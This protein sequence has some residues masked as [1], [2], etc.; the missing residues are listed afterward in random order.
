MSSSQLLSCV[1]SSIPQ[2]VFLFFFHPEIRS[3]FYHT[4]TSTQRFSV[5]CVT[6]CCHDTSRIQE[7]WRSMRY[8]RTGFVITPSIPPLSEESGDC[9]WA[10]SE[11]TEDGGGRNVRTTRAL[12]FA[13]TPFWQSRDKREMRMSIWN[14]R[15]VDSERDPHAVSQSEHKSRSLRHCK[16]PRECGEQLKWQMGHNL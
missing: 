12:Q 13:C 3:L 6:T 10:S 1:Y 5:W 15:C 9:A 16:C 8:G 7:I 14:L 2:C 4:V 11:G